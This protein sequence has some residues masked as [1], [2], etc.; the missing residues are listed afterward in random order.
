MKIVVTVLFLASLAAA[1][2]PADQHHDMVMKHGEQGMGFSQTA[3]THHFLASD[4]GG[5]I[6][7]EA[8]DP[9]DTKSRDEIRMH[10]GHI[11]KAFAAG[12]FDIPMFVHDTR[13][14]PGVQDMERLKSAIRYKYVETKAG[15]KVE[16]ASGNPEAIAAVHKFLRFQ[17]EE[18]RTGDPMPKE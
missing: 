11:A 7:V 1:Q 16:I 15:G 10:L 6:Q 14:V 9:K 3:T 8:K 2:T 5:A 12:D 17:I 13:T 4:S 18:H